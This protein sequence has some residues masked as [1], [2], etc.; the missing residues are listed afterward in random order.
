MFGFYYAIIGL[1][2]GFLCSKKAKEKG[3][4]YKDWF[5]L[6]FALNI[7]AYF[8]ISMVS[9]KGREAKE[10]YYREAQV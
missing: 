1:V 8:A 7:F 2:F 3:I 4:S 9:E 10:L 6:G 5:T